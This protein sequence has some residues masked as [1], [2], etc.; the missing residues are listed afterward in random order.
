[1]PHLGDKDD[2]FQ[3]TQ[4]NYQTQQT[5]RNDQALGA[6]SRLLNK[7]QFTVPSGSNQDPF[8]KKSFNV[9]SLVDSRGQ[10]PFNWNPSAAAESTRRVHFAEMEAKPKYQYSSSKQQM[11]MYSE[12]P[13]KQEANLQNV[14][15]DLITTFVN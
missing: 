2:L 4:S 13:D 6:T 15:K 3:M 14:N 8:G 1:M 7:E 11:D 5:D 12:N 10:E 9:I